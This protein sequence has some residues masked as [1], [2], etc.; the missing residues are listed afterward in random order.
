MSNYQTIQGKQHGRMLGT[1]YNH[2][3]KVHINKFKLYWR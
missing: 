3:E 2:K 1:E